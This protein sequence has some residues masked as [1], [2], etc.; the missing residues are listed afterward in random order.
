MSSRLSRWFG[1]SDRGDTARLEAF[2]DGVLAIAITLLIL[3]V[4]VETGRPLGEA[5]ARATP[6]IIAYAA[7]FLQIGIMWANHHILFRS[8]E[9]IDQLLLLANLLLLG[10]VSFLPFPTG[11]VAEHL[12][13]ADGR[14]AMLLYG[15]TLTACATAF[16]LVWQR[17]S[18]SG[19]LVSGISHEFR[20][21]VSRRYL[22]G[23]V[24]YAVAT[25]AA[26]IQPWL[27][28]ALSVLLALVFVLGPSPRQAG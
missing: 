5:L 25:A 13:G 24:G 27:T 22:L 9:R 28:L 2:S 14:V 23:L 1:A 8:V 7:T 11:L 10:C 19:L 3:E 18:R 21:D 20:R 12:T 15:G 6:H 26:L 17:A 4:H 16:N